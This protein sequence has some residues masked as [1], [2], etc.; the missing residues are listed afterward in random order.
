[1]ESQQ[2]Q[3]YRTLPPIQRE[4]QSSSLTGC[5]PSFS[6]SVVAVLENQTPMNGLDFFNSKYQQ[7]RHNLY[8]RMS[9]TTSS[10]WGQLLETWKGRQKFL[11]KQA[12]HLL[13]DRKMVNVSSR[14]PFN[15]HNRVIHDSLGSRS[16]SQSPGYNASEEYPT[17]DNDSYRLLH[18]QPS[19]HKQPYEQKYP[20]YYQ[21]SRSRSPSAEPAPTENEHEAVRPAAIL[22]LKLVGISESERGR[23][24]ERTA[25]PTGLGGGALTAQSSDMKA[26]N[27]SAASPP[28]SLDIN[29]INPVLSSW[30][31]PFPRPPFNRP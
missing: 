30:S 6:S 16:R 7:R 1:M 18:Q 24:R 17:D 5:S 12:R 29:F 15:L 27:P 22:S 13:R 19:S 26:T 23:T 25:K 10:G 8:R 9:R 4:V 3:T 31:D 21:T 14:L 2:L 20:V 11:Q 28:S